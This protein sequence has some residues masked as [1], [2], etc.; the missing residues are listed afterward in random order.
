MKEEQ[1]LRLIRDV[2][3]LLIEKVTVTPARSQR[4]VSS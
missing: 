2:T 1:E 4:K 3:G